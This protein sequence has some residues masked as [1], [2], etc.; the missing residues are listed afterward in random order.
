MLVLLC[1]YSVAIVYFDSLIISD[2][3][4]YPGLCRVG[5]VLFL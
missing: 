3:T 2:L 4:L 5:C 1:E